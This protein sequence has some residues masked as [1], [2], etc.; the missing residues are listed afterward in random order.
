MKKT[1]SLLLAVLLVFSLLA[2]CGGAAAPAPASSAEAPASEAA[3][4]P[5][6]AETAETA[7]EPEAVSAEEPASTLEEPPAEPEGYEY[8][9]EWAEYPLAEPG[10]L[11]LTMWCEFPGFL[12]R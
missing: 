2:G 12:S 9:G 3:P 11:S 4:E 6:T 5:E 8:T 10:E 7:P 1:L